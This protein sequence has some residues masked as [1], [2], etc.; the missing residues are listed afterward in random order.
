MGAGW[1]NVDIMK[2]RHRVT[3]VQQS[4]ISLLYPHGRGIEEEGKKESKG[5]NKYY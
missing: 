5:K 3:F 2:T 1:N 4:L